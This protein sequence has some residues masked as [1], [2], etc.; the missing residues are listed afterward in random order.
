MEQTVRAT[1]LNSQ[2]VESV[3]KLAAYLAAFQQRLGA[4]F[5]NLLFE[6]PGRDVLVKGSMGTDGRTRGRGVASVQNEDATQWVFAQSMG[7]RPLTQSRHRWIKAISD[8]RKV[9]VNSLHNLPPNHPTRNRRL[10]SSVRVAVIDD[11]INP[12]R[13]I[14]KGSVKIG[15]PRDNVK[16]H[17]NVGTP[18]DSTDGHGTLMANLVLSVCPFVDLYVAKLGTPPDPYECVAHQAAEVSQ[19]D[20]LA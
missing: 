15:W 20:S 7:S 8:F 13:L 6:P 10:Q 14:R 4:R 5:P 12:G 11:G 1:N 9:V 16:V 18:Y 19:P 2:S 17:G 3:S